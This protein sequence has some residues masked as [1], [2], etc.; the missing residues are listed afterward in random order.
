MAGGCDL[1]Q[2]PIPGAEAQGNVAT[3]ETGRAHGA[4][5]EPGDNPHGTRLAARSLRPLRVAVLGRRL[6]EPRRQLGADRG[7]TIA[8]PSLLPRRVAVAP[9]APAPRPSPRPAPAPAGPRRPQPTPAPAL[10]ARDAVPARAVRHR[11]PPGAGPPSPLRPGSVAAPRGQSSSTSSARSPTSPSRTTRPSPANRSRPT[12]AGERIVGTAPGNYGHAMIVALAAVGI[13]AG[14]YLPWISGTIGL[15]QFTPLGLRRRPRPRLLHRRHGPR[16]AA[17]LLSVRMRAF[18]WLT[19]ILSF[20]IA[21]FVVRDVLHSYDVMQEM[22]RYRS[23]DRRRGLGA[24]DHDRGG[25]HRDD[26]RG[27]PQRGRENRLTWRY[28]HLVACE[29]FTRTTSSFDPTEHTDVRHRRRSTTAWQPSA[30]ARARYVG[31]VAN[32]L[33]A[34]LTVEASWSIPCTVPA[35]FHKPRPRRSQVTFS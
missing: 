18:R 22:N 21:G 15:A 9:P 34:N 32:D 7:R 4:R 6:D 31:E 17:P 14:A 3:G 10:T 33:M 8:T 12:P 27:P 13:V 11:P 28:P 29:G 24:L 20:V 30:V 23:V 2:V 26:R 5:N 19:I 1:G 25:R 16:R 35:T